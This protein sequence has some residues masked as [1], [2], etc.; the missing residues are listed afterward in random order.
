MSKQNTSDQEMGKKSV[1]SSGPEK[2]G[3]GT[4]PSDSGMT[5][6]VSPI[7]SLE[8]SKKPADKSPVYAERMTKALDYFQSFLKYGT[9]KK[10][11]GESGDEEG[12]KCF[13]AEFLSID[14]KPLK[15]KFSITGKGNSQVYFLF[16]ILSRISKCKSEKDLVKRFLKHCG[17]FLFY[18]KTFCRVLLKE[19]CRA[20]ISLDVPGDKVLK[21]VKIPIR[22]SLNYFRVLKG[23][24]NLIL[25]KTKIVGRFMGFDYSSGKWILKTD[26]NREFWKNRKA[27][28]AED[29]DGGNTGHSLF[30]HC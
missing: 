8:L 14:G 7:I 24:K 1:N 6:E 13:P 5:T 15:F 3:P 26:D 23:N 2:N 11:L 12:D 29:Q 19:R 9:R 22:D 28:K 4:G 18:L 10:I 16:D 21:S 30:M 20:R 25:E 27:F 17:H